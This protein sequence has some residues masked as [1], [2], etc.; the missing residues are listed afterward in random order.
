MVQML[1]VTHA[2]Q[3]AEDRCHDRDEHEPDDKAHEAPPPPSAAASSRPSSTAL[4]EGTSCVYDLS[5]VAISACPSQPLT[6]AAGIPFEIAREAK[7][8]RSACSASRSVSPFSIPACATARRNARSV[9]M[10][11][12][13]LPRPSTKI[14]SSGPVFLLASSCSTSAAL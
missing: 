2:E 8:C 10:Y 3:E 6:L 1:D 7:E 11:G 12:R 13:P 9:L 4:P 14:S 5:V